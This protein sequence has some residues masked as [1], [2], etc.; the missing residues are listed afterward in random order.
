MSSNERSQLIDHL[1]TGTIDRR[2]LVGG[3]A[4]LATAATAALAVGSLVSAQSSDT[5]T[6]TPE[7]GSGSSSSGSSSSSRSTTSV[8]DR[9]A[10]VIASVQADRDALA[11]SLDTASIDELLSLANEL[12][13]KAVAAADTSGSGSGSGSGRGSSRGSSSSSSSSSAT[14]EASSSSTPAASGS[15]STTSSPG[16]RQLANAATRTAR[17]ARAMIVAQ[18][19]NFGLPSQQNRV[20]RELAE[21]YDGVKEVAGDTASAG[22]DDATTLV[23]HAED[24]YKSAYDAYNAKTYARATAYGEAAVYLAEAA[25]GLLGMFGGM[26]SGGDSGRRSG[27][28]GGMGGGRGGNGNAGSSGNNRG[29]NSGGGSSSGSSSS[30]TATPSSSG[31]GSSSS[32]DET[33]GDESTP[34]EVPEPSF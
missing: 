1:R 20:S 10:A 12:Q 17:A 27:G 32:D 3:A 26:G 28:R 21:V 9:S 5:A 34:V 8:T 14:P 29:S 33:G 2:H 25:A 19:A 31:S 24:A 11:S 16:K 7:A 30:A 15:A 22:I 6:A 4:G 18:L 13:T 23:T